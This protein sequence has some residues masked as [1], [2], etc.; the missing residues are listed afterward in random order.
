MVLAS[1]S[2]CAQTVENDLADLLNRQDYLALNHRYKTAKDSIQSEAAKLFIEA[3]LNSAFNKLHESNETL[4]NLLNN[5]QSELD[6][7]RII[8][9]IVLLSDNLKRQGN[10]G[11]SAGLLQNF[12]DQM[13]AF[14]VLDSSVVDGLKRLSL[15]KAFGNGM[16]PEIIRPERDCMIS[17]SQEGVGNLSYID[18]E[19]NGNNTRFVFDTGADGYDT[20]LVTEAFAR[21]NGI[22]ILEDS[23]MITGL[24]EKF[25]RLG[26]A[27]SVKIGDILYKNVAF[28]I[29]EGDNL[30]PIDTLFLDAILGSVFMKA[31]GEVQIFPKEKKILFPYVESQPP[32][33]GSN[34]VF[35][36]GQ[37]YVETFSGDG[38]LLMHFDTGGGI[39]LSSKYYQEHK[40]KVEAEG[41]LYTEGGVGGFGAV[42]RMNKYILPSFSLRVGSQTKE[43]KDVHVLTE[44]GSA[45]IPADGSFGNDFV[46]LFDK[47]TIN[48]NKMF[49]KFE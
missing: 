49:I 34:M 5:Y 41:I 25:V 22:R 11:D 16:K 31:M 47:V 39:G 17:Y 2:F 4:G 32:V 38:R 9:S 12:I 33:G 35:I 36:G 8:A 10:Y 24:A 29:A 30:L 37:P 20:N 3:N 6:L 27:D 18:V 40:E 42:V 7:N 46:D 14:N 13:L 15:W 21:K 23:A 45:S 1:Q 28:T 26:V 48:Y 44:G 19:L 43:L